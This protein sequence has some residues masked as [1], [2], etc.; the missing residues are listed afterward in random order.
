[1]SKDI[2]HSKKLLL[3]WKSREA[4][5]FCATFKAKVCLWNTF[6]QAKVSYVLN[7]DCPTFIRNWCL[8]RTDY[9]CA[10]SPL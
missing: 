7:F 1:M 10:V 2:V 8:W 3:I 9:F 6:D 4:D 5:F